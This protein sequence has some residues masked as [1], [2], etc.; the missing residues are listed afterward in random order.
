[1]SKNEKSSLNDSVRNESKKWFKKKKMKA[2]WDFEYVD[3]MNKN[4]ENK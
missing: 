4:K 2:K 1:M 3:K